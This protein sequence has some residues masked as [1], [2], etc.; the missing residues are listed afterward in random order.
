MNI[1]KE[2]TNPL[3]AVLTMKIEKSDY[4]ERVSNELKK[5][6]QK[7][8]VK[9][10]RKGMVPLGIVKKM[11]GTPILVEEINKLVSENLTKYLIEEKVDIL[12]E[13]LP[14]RDEQKAIDWDTQE[15]FEFSFDLGLSPQFDLNP[16]ESDQL[17]YYIIKVNDDM[18]KEQTNYYAKGSGKFVEVDIVSEESMIK[19][20][21]TE[22][23]SEGNILADGITTSDAS[24]YAKMIKDEEIQKQFIGANKKEILTVDV[25]KAF[26]N[27]A[28]LA[29]MLKIE[30]EKVAE[31]NN[32]F[33]F[34]L[35]EISDY[36][37]ADVNQ[38]LF[39]KVFGEGV[40]KSEEE[41]IEKV[42]GQIADGLIHES[43]YKFNLDAKEYLLEN[44]K[45]DLPVEFLKRWLVEV[46]EE[47]TEEKIDADWVHFE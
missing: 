13:P 26:P 18:I 22:L 25:K 31:I 24:V 3:S 11:Y 21:I 19:A 47:I 42:K 36:V 4:E 38:E 41:F 7:A 5:Y 8:D 30:K 12:G 43:N 6:R 39:D 2:N 45:F 17:P 1:S 10:F 34:T 46:N 40:I 20:D 23:D 35:N 29:G 9:G 28:D 14:S 15:E 16:G 33:Q 32:N 44:C 27:D 37:Q